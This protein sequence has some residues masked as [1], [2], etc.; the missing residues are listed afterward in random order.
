MTIKTEFFLSLALLS[1]SLTLL[2]P[3][4][5]SRA[6]GIACFVLAEISAVLLIAHHLADQMTCEGI[7]EVALYH[8]RYGL[9]Y[10]ASGAYPELVVNG[11]LVLLGIILVFGCFAFWP[12]LRSGRTSLVVAPMLVWASLLLNPVP[13]NLSFHSENM[14]SN[15]K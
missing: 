4:M 11:L 6:W 1:C 12:R 15:A 3:S 10:A 5:K 8:I 13:R 14:I 9:R 2:Y 7:N